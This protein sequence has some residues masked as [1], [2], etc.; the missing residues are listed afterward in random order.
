MEE[1]KERV[2]KEYSRGER[3][4]KPMAFRIDN[5]VVE[6][7]AQVRNKGRLI[8]Q[9]VRDWARAKNRDES[10]EDID[11]AWNQIEDQMK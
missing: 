7:L 4:Q 10:G 3:S 2:R 5:D 8:N 1:K 11:P 6:I 9:L